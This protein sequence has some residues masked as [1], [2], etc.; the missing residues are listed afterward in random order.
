MQGQVFRFQIED[1]ARIPINNDF[2]WNVQLFGCLVPQEGINS[3]PDIYI[4]D[5]IKIYRCPYFSGRFV[6]Y[7]EHVL[8]H[9]TF[10]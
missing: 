10:D 7:I 3:I 4:W 8:C 5:L 1:A 2:C 9:L 6:L